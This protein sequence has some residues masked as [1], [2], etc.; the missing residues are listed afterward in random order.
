[1]ATGNRN[2][3]TPAVDQE[4]AEASLGDG[5]GE[6]DRSAACA[7]VTPEAHQLPRTI[8]RRGTRARSSSRGLCARG[9]RSESPC[10]ER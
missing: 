4:R 8:E 7:L 9:M 10:T 6:R 3:R 1:M 2:R 5:R